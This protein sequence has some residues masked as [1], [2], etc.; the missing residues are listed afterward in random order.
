MNLLQQLGALKRQFSRVE[1]SFAALA[2][3]LMALAKAADTHGSEIA[4]LSERVAQLEAKSR[5]EGQ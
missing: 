3:T 5:G 2:P 1:E 4:A